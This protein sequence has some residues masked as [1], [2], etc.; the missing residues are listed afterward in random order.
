MALSDAPRSATPA[1]RCAYDRLNTNDARRHIRAW[2]TRGCDWR[3]LHLIVDGWHCRT[4]DTLT[5]AHPPP[6]CKED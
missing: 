1:E 3:M 6:V 4:H 2:R 5:E